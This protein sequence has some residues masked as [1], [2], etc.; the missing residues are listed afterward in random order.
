M[1]KENRV[2]FESEIEARKNVCRP[3]GHCLKTT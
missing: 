2:L 1:N 3:R